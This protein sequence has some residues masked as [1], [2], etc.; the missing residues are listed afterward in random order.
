VPPRSPC[1]TLSSP[2]CPT[3]PRSSP[4]PGLPCSGSSNALA[5]RICPRKRCPSIAPLTALC[6]TVSPGL[7]IQYRYDNDIIILYIIIYVVRGVISHFFMGC[8][9]NIENLFNLLSYNRIIYSNTSHSHGRVIPW[10]FFNT[11]FVQM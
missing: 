11:L 5:R 4:L 10:I 9:T 6:H 2:P 8:K 7:Y 3:W 1:P